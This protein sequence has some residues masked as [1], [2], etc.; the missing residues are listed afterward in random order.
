LPLT[1]KKLAATGKYYAL[2]AIGCVIGANR[3]TKIMFGSR[4]RA[5]HLAQM[6]NGRPIIVC[7]LTFGHFR[8][9]HRSRGLKGREQGFE[10]V[11]ARFA[12]RIFA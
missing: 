9:G 7:V 2:I 6:D 5:V 4:R 3:L 8:H 12:M 1:A 11:W 10:A